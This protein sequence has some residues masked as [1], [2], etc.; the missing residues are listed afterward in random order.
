MTANQSC[1]GWATH[2]RMWPVKPN[3][4]SLNFFFFRKKFSNVFKRKVDFK[5]FFWLNILVTMY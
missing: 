4:L 2:V 3:F 1:I 5:F